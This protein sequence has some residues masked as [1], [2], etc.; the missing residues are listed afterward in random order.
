MTSQGLE[1]ARR[2]QEWQREALANA[3]RGAARHTVGPFEVQLAQEPGAFTW[4][5]IVDGGIT[6]E[7]VRKSIE[8]LRGLFAGRE[9]QLEVE[10]NEGALPQ[11]GRWLEAGG[12]ELVERNP[13]MSCRPSSFGPF[14]APD[15]RLQQLEPSSA[16]DELEAFQ[17]IRWT[18]GNLGVATPPPVDRLLREMALPSSVYLLATIDGQPAGTGVSHALSG[19]AEIVGIVT[20]VEM[21]R[22]GVAATVSSELVTRHF[23]SG[24]DFVFLDA[25]NDAAVRVYERLGFTHFGANLVYRYV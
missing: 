21:R 2:F 24:G 16:R 7:A 3:P 19:A 10:L 20:R 23:S 1:D 15:V 18:E 22:R 4:V 11:A 14:T 6:E 12:F 25:A 5:V 17:A 8:P 9:H 13:L